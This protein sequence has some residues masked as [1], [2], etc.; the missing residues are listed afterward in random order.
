M[1]EYIFNA[2]SSPLYPEAARLFALLAYPNH[3]IKRTKTEEALRCV[4]AACGQEM[5]LLS[6]RA[7]D[8]LIDPATVDKRMKSFYLEIRRR[9]SAADAMNLILLGRE[10]EGLDGPLPRRL[11]KTGHLKAQARQDSPAIE[12]EIGS[13]YER[14]K[15]IPSIPVLHLAM[16][17]NQTVTMRQKNTILPFMFDAAHFKSLIYLSQ[18]MQTAILSVPEAAISPTDLINIAICSGN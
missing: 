11:K 10:G 12:G 16:A 4:G 9:L 8:L 17:L 2:E 18:T 15:W 7:K 14:Q 6:P 3:A 1:A 13:N 5:G